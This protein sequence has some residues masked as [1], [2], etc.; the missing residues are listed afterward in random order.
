MRTALTP[1]VDPAGMSVVDRTLISR[2]TE[3]NEVISMSTTTT[4]PASPTAINT[5]A[6]NTAANHTVASANLSLTEAD[7]R[8]ILLEQNDRRRVSGFDRVVMRISLVTLLWA[9]HHA[10]PA[11]LPH[12]EQLRIVL[13]DRAREERFQRGC[14]EALRLR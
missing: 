14:L 3:Q 8:A 6:I 12:E 10:E 1:I 11:S 4:A 13:N 9:R 2:T 5:D 7:L